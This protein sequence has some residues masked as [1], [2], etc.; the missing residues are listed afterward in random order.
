VHEVIDLYR[1]QESGIEIRLNSDPDLPLVEADTGRIGQILHNLLRNSIEALEGRD[2]GVIELR[3]N[4]S[5]Y[6]DVAVVELVVTDNGPGFQTGSVSQVFEPYVT[7]KPKGTGLGLSIVKKLVEEHGG[8][9]DAENREEGG[10]IIR[11]KIPINE[12]ARESMS[13]LLPGR[14]DRRRERA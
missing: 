2:D 14:A 3:V 6:Q 9:I 11:I 12:A 8:I 4:A 5:E 7:T 13:A 1:G 10:A